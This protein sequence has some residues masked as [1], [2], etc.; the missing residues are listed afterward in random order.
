[1]GKNFAFAIL[2]EWIGQKVKIL[3]SIAF[4]NEIK[5]ILSEIGTDHIVV[6]QDIINIRYVV[7]TRG[8]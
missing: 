1:M 6:G 2:Q 8:A 5:S 4:A 3:T 7:K